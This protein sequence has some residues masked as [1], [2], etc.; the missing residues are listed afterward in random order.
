M[1]RKVSDLKVAELKVELEKRGL[2]SKGLKGVLVQRL[3]KA[4]EDEGGNGNDIENVVSE[5][6]SPKASRRSTGRL[7]RTTENEDDQ[8]QEEKLQ[9]PEPQSDDNKG[10]KFSHSCNL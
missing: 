3:Q 10:K 4:I 7:K 2:D 6:A 9:T 1:K 8:F 5:T